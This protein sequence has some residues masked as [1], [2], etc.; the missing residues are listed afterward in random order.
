MG[1]ISILASEN[2]FRY[3]HYMLISYSCMLAPLQKKR[4]KNK[5]QRLV[6]AE[7]SKRKAKGSYSAFCRLP[8]SLPSFH[9][10]VLAA[11]AD[12][13]MSFSSTEGKKQVPFAFCTLFLDMYIYLYKLGLGIVLKTPSGA[14]IICSPCC[15]QGRVVSFYV[16]NIYLSNCF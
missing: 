2:G 1:L 16:W 9:D 11:A 15:F 14:D 7:V 8:E 12:A 3:P 4:L 13:A 6:I 10:E 5:K